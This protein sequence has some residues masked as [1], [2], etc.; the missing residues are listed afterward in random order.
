MNIYDIHQEIL[1]LANNLKLEGKSRGCFR[2]F[3]YG[4][5]TKVAGL[6]NDANN[7]R[8]AAPTNE[9][10]YDNDLKNF[11]D[12]GCREGKHVI[13]KNDSVH[14]FYRFLIENS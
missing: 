5:Q 7:F 2:T 3:F 13:L 1:E 10:L 12:S 8:K 6:Q 14:Y 11:V 4:K 9:I